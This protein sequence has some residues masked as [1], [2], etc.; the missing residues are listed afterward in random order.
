M[1]NPGRSKGTELTRFY[2]YV[3]TEAHYRDKISYSSI[4]AYVMK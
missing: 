1:E 4:V 3:S 2:T